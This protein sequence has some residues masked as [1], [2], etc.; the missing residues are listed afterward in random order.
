MDNFA[1]L[2]SY[3]E[4]L[5]GVLGHADRKAGL[6]GYCQGLMLPIKRKSVEPLAAYLDPA[7]VQAK[8]QSLHHF[9]AQSPWSDAAVL[10]EV[11]AIVEPVLGLDAG[12]YWIIDD[13]GS[14]KQ[15]R[16]SVG[17]TRQ[18]CGQL[19]KTDNCQVAVSLSLASETGSLPIKWQLYLPKEWTDDPK[20]C[21]A[22]GV[23]DEVRFA[24]KPEIALRQLREAR[25]EG[26][27]P[28]VV[29][30]DPA[31]GTET[32]FRD[33]V[34]AL[35][36]IYMLGIKST[37]GVWAPGVAPLPPKPWTGQGRRPKLLR[38]APGHEPI[39]AKALAKELPPRAWH[40]VAW[41]EGTNETLISRFA[42]VRVRPAHPD[43]WSEIQR[44]EEWLLIEWPDGDTE[45]LKYWLSTAPADATLDQLVF[46]A[47]MRWRIERDYR[48]LKQEF[49][50]SHY[51]GRNWRGLH[52]HATLCIAAY[53]FLLHQRLTQGSKKNTARPQAPALPEGYVPRGGRS[54]TAPRP[55]FDCHSA[56][57][58]QSAHRRST[59][60]M[61]LLR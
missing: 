47:K 46:V 38:R 18:Y 58:H 19:G 15:G 7:H 4:R 28:G 43:Y 41:R 60:T 32:A 29:L 9:V 48:E 59:P 23:P 24:T 1:E 3:L 53:G 20:R 11:R 51:E 54:N 40:T 21:Q 30:A 14:P 25:D 5:A 26:I 37:I 36:L 39:S 22:V 8:H 27:P 34:T 61:S 12:S 16:H 42:A 17:V 10:G 45:P 2:E 52:H 55:G 6:M 57:P 56:L 44:A 13:T 31:Y 35:G 50:L 33:G 49:G